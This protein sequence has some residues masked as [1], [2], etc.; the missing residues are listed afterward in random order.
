MAEAAPAAFG[1]TSFERY[2]GSAVP[3]LIAAAIVTAS[4]RLRSPTLVL[5][6]LVLGAY[7]VMAFLHLYVP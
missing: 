7:A 4:P 5:A 3:L 1:M 6:P 2:A